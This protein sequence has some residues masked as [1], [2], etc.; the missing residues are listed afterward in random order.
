MTMIVTQVGKVKYY[1]PVVRITVFCS[2]VC[3][4]LSEV[5]WCK[6]VLVCSCCSSKQAREK[7]EILKVQG[8][9]NILVIKPIYDILLARE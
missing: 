4:V 8:N 7:A 9:T 5:I 6:C 2:L 1:F 3:Y